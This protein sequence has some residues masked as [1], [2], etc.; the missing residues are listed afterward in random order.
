[1]GAF[2]LSTGRGWIRVAVVLFTYKQ[3]LNITDNRQLVFA[4]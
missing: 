1:M 4:A 3:K 2:W